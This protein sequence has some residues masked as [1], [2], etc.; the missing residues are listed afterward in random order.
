MS[1]HPSRAGERPPE[2]AEGSSASCRNVREGLG[3][4]ALGLGVRV[5]GL[6]QF[7]V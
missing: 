5:L 3:F 2:R 1:A 7:R 4:R 6:G